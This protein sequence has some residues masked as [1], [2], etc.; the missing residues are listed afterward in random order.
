MGTRKF[1]VEIRP[2]RRALSAIN[3]N[4]VGAQ[5]QHCVVNKRVLSE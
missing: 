1:G 3:H 5:P 2:N 4:V